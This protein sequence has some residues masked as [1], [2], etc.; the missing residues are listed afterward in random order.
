MIS[1]IICEDNKHI[2]DVI[3]KVIDRTMMK[4]KVPY[5]KSIYYDYNKTFMKIIDEKLPNKVYILDIETPSASG[6]DVVRK[7][8]EKDLNSIIIFL[9]SH[10]ELGYTILKQE[11]M[12][13]SFICKFDDYENKLEQSIRKALKVVGQKL[14]LSI[15]DHGVVYNIPLDDIIYIT[16]DSVE[17]KCIIKT[18][19]N[20]FKVNKPLA[21]ILELLDS[22]FKQSHRACIVNMDRVHTIN[23]KN[24]TIGFDN[25]IMVDL[26]N[27]DFKK[28]VVV[29]NQ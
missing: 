14:I 29:V 27:D 3:I 16:R 24:K 2:N 9:T 4:N 15:S 28:E 8:R 17:R 12:F 10:D 20:E 25:G 7:I 23:K 6:I 18:D 22:R 11:F 19:Y 1:F 21:E 13:L 5:K 26:M